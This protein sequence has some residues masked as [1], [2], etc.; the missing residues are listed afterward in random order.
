[1]AGYTTVTFSSTPTFTVTKNTGQAFLITLT[2]DVS[3]STMD[4][5]GITGTGRTRITF[6]I[7]QDGFGNHTFAWP[8]NEDERDFIVSDANKLAVKHLEHWALWPVMATILTGPRKSGRSLLGRIFAAKVGGRLI[9]SADVADEEMIFHAWNAAQADRK[10]LLL[11]ADLPPARWRIR[12]PDLK[13]RLLASPCV[14]I[15]EPDAV[16][17]S[18]LVH[19]LLVARGLA[20][21]QEVLRYVVPRIERSYIGVGRIVDALD[22]AALERRKPVSLKIARQALSTLGVTDDTYKLL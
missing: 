21:P 4:T 2:G 7:V 22:E 3:S 15:E 6:R 12:L 11:I 20:V 17:M 18:A 13:S 9:D 19:K 8:A 1:M 5:S 14:A 16:L 10:P